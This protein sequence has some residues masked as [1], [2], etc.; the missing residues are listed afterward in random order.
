[1]DVSRESQEAALEEPGGEELI[2]SLISA[3]G[4][5]EP[6][7]EQELQT[8]LQS[9]GHSSADLTLDELRQAMAAYLEAVH[10]ELLKDSD[11]QRDV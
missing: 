8:I 6:L 7:I 5:P 10:H 11:E 4:L 9:S 3:T 2:S 1:M